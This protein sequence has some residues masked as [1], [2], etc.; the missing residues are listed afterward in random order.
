MAANQTVLQTWTE[1]YQQ[2]FSGQENANNVRFTKESMMCTEKRVLIKK[3]R[4]TRTKHEICHSELESK[5]KKQF[6][7]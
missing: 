6:M 7:E 3:S 5:T 1:V 2:I 4:Q